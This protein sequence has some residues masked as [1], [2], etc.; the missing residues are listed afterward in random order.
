MKQLTTHD[1]LDAAFGSETAILFKHNTTCPISANAHR[2]MESFVE[3]SP[4][5]PV[6]LID[7][8]EH[9]DVSNAVAERTGIEHQS[10]QVIVL[11]GGRPAWDAALWDINAAAL[12]D[13]VGGAGNG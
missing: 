2:E 7:I 4:D 9:R 6:Y 1:D 3:G 11:R 5:A 13:Q 10:P 12:R 8:M